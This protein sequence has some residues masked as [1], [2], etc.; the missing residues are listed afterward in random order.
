ML[1]YWLRR[2]LKPSPTERCISELCQLSGATVPLTAYTILCVRFV[3]FVHRHSIGS[4]T[5][6]TLDTGEWLALTRRGLAPR[7][8]HQASPA[9]TCLWPAPHDGQQ[10]LTNHQP[11]MREEYAKIG[12]SGPKSRALLCSASLPP[13]P[14]LESHNRQLKLPC[15]L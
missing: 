3:H 7:K 14:P 6:A 11:V 8:T 2:A 1:L 15:S 4:A 12:D 10:T 9:I 13:M 5:D